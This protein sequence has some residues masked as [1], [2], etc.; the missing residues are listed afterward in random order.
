MSEQARIT[1]TLLTPTLVRGVIVRRPGGMAAVGALDA[2]RHAV[3]TM[4]RLRAAHG[5]GPVRTNLFGRRAVLLLE[6]DQ[7]RRVLEGTPEPFTSANAE[8]QGALSHFQPHGVLISE[9][10]ER[11][12]RREFNETALDTPHRVH[13]LA[14]SFLAVIREEVEILDRALGPDGEL[15]WSRFAPSFWN[16][17]RRIVLGDAARDDQRL[18]DLLYRLRS[19]SNWFY[20][21]PRRDRLRAGFGERLRAHLDRADPDSLAGAF[22]GDRAPGGVDPAGQAP[23]WL[24]AFDAAVIAAFRALALIASH[25]EQAEVLRAE[26][27]EH[28][29]AAP[30]GTA[31]LE[32][33]RATVLESVRLWPTTLAILR[34]STEATEWDGAVVPA[35]TAF[36][37]LSAF[38]HRDPERL[39]YADLFA[40]EVWL[41]GTAEEDGLVPFSGGPADCA[42]RNLVLFTTTA[43][44]AALLERRDLRLVEPA[45]LRPDRPLPYSLNHFALRMATRPVR[46]HGVPGNRPSP[47]RRRTDSVQEGTTTMAN[48]TFIEVQKALSGVDYPANR[49]DL[50]N[51]ARGRGAEDRVLEALRGV[52]DRSY[53]GPDEV[54][55]AVSETTGGR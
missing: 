13:A 37:I 14:D 49:D 25:P 47:P 52:A 55:K 41:D 8:K 24:F 12:R 11:Q 46:P 45:A 23:H 40:P 26:L 29:P 31:R 33:L 19:D 9:G 15:T 32:R 39:P 34:D 21:R 7:V 43:L 2:D 20:L 36:V 3:E 53:S 30:E 38:F 35:G 16:A 27:D 48:P 50:V 6:P 54:S 17:V 10:Q 1:A 51:H 4:R 44:L 42:G 22:A 5:P 18:T 28:N